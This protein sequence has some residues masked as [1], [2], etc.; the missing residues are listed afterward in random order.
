MEEKIDEAVQIKVS[1]ASS[2]N[3]PTGSLTVTSSGNH[4]KA[5]IPTGRIWSDQ[6]S[7]KDYVQLFNR[8]K[9]TLDSK[10]GAQQS[11]HPD[12]TYKGLA[13]SAVTLGILT[14]MILWTILA[15]LFRHHY[16]WH[17]FYAEIGSLAIMLGLIIRF[18]GPALCYLSD[19][20]K[21]KNAFRL[22][23]LFLYIPVRRSRFKY[24]FSYRIQTKLFNFYYGTGRLEK[25][26]RLIQETIAMLQKMELLENPLK[27][28]MVGERSVARAAILAKLGYA[29]DAQATATPAKDI[30]EKAQSTKYGKPD[31][32]SNIRFHT[33]L[34][35]YFEHVGQYNQ[36]LEHYRLALTSVLSGAGND[37]VLMALI[38]NIGSAYFK[39]GALEQAQKWLEL[40]IDFVKC[41]Q[42]SSAI[43]Q[44]TKIDLLTNY[45]SVQINRG[46]LESAAEHLESAKKL[47]MRLP[48][49]PMFYSI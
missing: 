24:P 43:E 21:R 7:S 16:N 37:D 25:A 46:N 27:S 35:L 4:D 13:T 18:C 34:G 5:V 28:A 32:S 49:Q 15:P 10:G 2:S 44:K 41:N 26:D 1:T 39:S 22:A 33:N 17:Y 9:D 36:S 23:E 20:C 30:F 14:F 48:I 8:A 3:E 38:N 29:S 31:E 40:G 19:W 42:D 45:A 12:P 47:S 11:A 6:D